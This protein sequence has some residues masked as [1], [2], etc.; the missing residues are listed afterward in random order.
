MSL[1]PRN[2]T[3][4]TPYGSPA[5]SCFRAAS[6]NSFAWRSLAPPEALQITRGCPAAGRAPAQ[7]Y[8]PPRASSH[9]STQKTAAQKTVTYGGLAQQRQVFT[10]FMAAST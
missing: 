2:C 3:F 1:A 7:V 4:L 5:A 6:P 10:P 8:R 9:S